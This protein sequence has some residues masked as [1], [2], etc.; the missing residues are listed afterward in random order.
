MIVPRLGKAALGDLGASCSAKTGS[1]V[2]PGFFVCTRVFR[3]SPAGP[4]GLA[5]LLSK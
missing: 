5:G 1:R 4:A 3:S 2:S